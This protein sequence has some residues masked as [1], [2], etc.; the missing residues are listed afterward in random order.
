[1]LP[2]EPPSVSVSRCGSTDPD[3]DPFRTVV[4]VRGDHDI[5]TRALLSG[6][7]AQAARHG[8]VDVV[9]DLSGVTF[10]DASTIGAIVDARNRLRA[11]AR[12]LSVRA[13][14]VRPRGLLDICGLAFLIDEEPAVAQ[15]REDA[16]LSSWVSVPAADRASGALAPPPAL[17]GSSPEPARVAAPRPGASAASVRQPRPPS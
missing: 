1:M 8:D 12:S 11:R 10:M 2:T 5:A 7:F 4:W 16:A 6:T 17:R 9:V 14:P 13:V 3:S 15:L